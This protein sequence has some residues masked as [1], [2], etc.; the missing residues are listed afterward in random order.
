[1]Q[2]TLVKIP[3]WLTETAS[4]SQLFHG[5]Y[6]V[7]VFVH[8]NCFMVP[9]VSQSQHP[10]HIL[11]EAAEGISAFSVALVYTYNYLPCSIGSPVFVYHS[12]PGG[13]STVWWGR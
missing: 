10:A 4:R 7:D 2:N 11:I 13:S 5:L 3:F 12:R 8:L 9:T 6:S 1:M